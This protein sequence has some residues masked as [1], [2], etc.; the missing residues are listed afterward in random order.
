MKDKTKLIHAG[1]AP[2]ENH[3]VVNPPV[4]HAS[5]ILY[6]TKED[7]DNYR[8]KATTYGRHGTPGIQAF[9]DAVAALEGADKCLVTPSGVAAITISLLSFLKSGDHLLV[10]DNAY[11]PTRKFCDLFL[12]KYGIETTYFDPLIG[13]N[14]K[15]LIRENTGG[16]MLES[17]GSHTFEVTDIPAIIETLRNDFSAQ[18]RIITFMDNTWATPLFFKPLSFGVDISI[19]SATKYIGGHAD[20]M[21]GTLSF[22]DEH[23]RQIDLTRRLLGNSVGPDDV[24]L[25]QRGLRSLDARLKQHEAHA[26]T[27]AKWLQQRPEVAKVMYPAL[28]EDPGHAIWKRDFT[29]ATGLFGFMLKE[30]REEQVSRLLNS[31]TLFGM[32]FSWGGYESLLIPSHVEDSRTA[33]SWQPPGPVFRIHVGL[34]D[35]EDLIEDL[36]KG[37][38]AFHAA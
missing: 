13:S 23:W 27:I 29:G 28:P 32:G 19:Q 11:E 30:G 10:S 25:A 9:A 20:V 3:G 2:F 12:T 22:Q 24:Y 17:P 35:P 34:E 16:I 18:R 37:F 7:M 38:E 31:L 14:I 36:E 15:S 6:E 33:T 8:T 21:L 4:Y 26:L 5:T 1:R